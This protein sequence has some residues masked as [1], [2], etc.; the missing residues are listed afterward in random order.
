MACQS[1]DSKKD[2]FLFPGQSCFPLSPCKE[3]SNVDTKSQNVISEN[4]Q[5]IKILE[6]LGPL[7]EK[8]SSFVNSPNVLQYLNQVNDSVK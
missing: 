4:D 8:D 2:R 7:E 3:P 1:K 5:L 6:L